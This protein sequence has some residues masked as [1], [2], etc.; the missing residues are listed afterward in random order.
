MQHDSKTLTALSVDAEQPDPTRGLLPG[1]SIEHWEARRRATASAEDFRA[2]W[3]TAV[4]ALQ[5]AS[6]HVSD[7]RRK[8]W[9]SALD[10]LFDKATA[11]IDDYR[12]GEYRWR[13]TYAEERANR[14]G[15]S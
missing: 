12:A 14:G 2:G 8:A 13:K 5:D 10:V 7:T 11:A 15:A 9:W 4:E 6:K 3:F 1:E